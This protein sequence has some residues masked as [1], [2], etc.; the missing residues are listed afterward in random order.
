[1]RAAFALDRHDPITGYL[2]VTNDGNP[3]EEVVSITLTDSFLHILD[4]AS[5]GAPYDTALWQGAEVT[6]P[7]KIEFSLDRDGT[8]R[9]TV[10]PRRQWR[11]PLPTSDAWV[12]RGFSPRRHFRIERIKAPD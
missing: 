2:F 11:L 3:F 1:M 6:G 12:W 8:W 9:L 5:L 7:G 10:L 4:R